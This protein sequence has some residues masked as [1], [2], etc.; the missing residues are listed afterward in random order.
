MTDVVTHNNNITKQPD[1]SQDLNVGQD[2][3]ATKAE[4][5]KLATEQKRAQLVADLNSK[6]VTVNRDGVSYTPDLYIY[7]AGLTL[8][9]DD[10]SGGARV[11]D[12]AQRQ[13]GQ[14]TKDGEFVPTDE[15]SVSDKANL[16]LLDSLIQQG[17]S[18]ETATLR[19]TGESAVGSQLSGTPNYDTPRRK[20][21]MNELREK[22]ESLGVEGTTV[23]GVEGTFFNLQGVNGGTPM[24][25]TINEKS[26]V[27]ELRFPEL[28]GFHTYN[29]LS[30]ILEKL[31]S[32][33]K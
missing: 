9:G 2:L 14:I 27:V 4:Q 19:G 32:Y 17:L 8:V 28:G 6:A 11:L 25:L 21:L 29:E 24:S 3:I 18:A 26:G 1:D 22:L 16:Q 10:K 7:G 33:K 5:Y 15:T 30:F 23:P 12:Q 31:N 13:I 20:E